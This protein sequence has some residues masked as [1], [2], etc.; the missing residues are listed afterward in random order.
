M[1]AD[2]PDS[3]ICAKPRLWISDV[4][5]G[6]SQSAA[7]HHSSV[8]PLLIE[9]LRRD[10]ALFRRVVELSQ[11]HGAV[12]V[13]VIELEELKVVS[14]APLGVRG[15]HSGLDLLDDFVIL[16]ELL[17]LLVSLALSNTGL[18]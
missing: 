4:E 11:H 2:V 7:D 6:E 15:G 1:G 12:A 14:V 3:H 8:A 18:L 9:A 5:G 17:A 10:A 13:F 16:G